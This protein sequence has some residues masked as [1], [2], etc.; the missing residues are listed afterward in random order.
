MTCLE[1]TSDVT[2]VPKLFQR[3]SP[4]CRIALVNRVSAAS[5]HP[6]FSPDCTRSFPCR[7]QAGSAASRTGGRRTRTS[8]GALRAV[9]FFARL[10]DQVPATNRF[11]PSKTTVATRPAHSDPVALGGEATVPRQRTVTAEQATG[12]RRLSRPV[13]GP[14]VAVPVALTLSLRIG[15]PARGHGRRRFSGRWRRRHRLL[16]S[17]R[18]LSRSTA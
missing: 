13:L 11:A 2:G 8:L 4:S 10:A 5:A 9:G 3:V 16:L 15:V 18:R 17:R 7:F 12:P 14:V 6:R 1:R